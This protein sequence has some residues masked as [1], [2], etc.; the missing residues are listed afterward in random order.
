MLLNII[1][2]VLKNFF[3]ENTALCYAFGNFNRSDELKT[4]LSAEL[5]SHWKSNPFTLRPFEDTMV[6]REFESLITRFND[7]VS[8]ADI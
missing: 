8:N 2:A 6:P 4:V 1:H 5:K 3:D 7:Y